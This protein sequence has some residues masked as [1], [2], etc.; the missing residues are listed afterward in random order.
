MER[1]SG[2]DYEY[3]PF[4]EGGRFWTDH[5]GTTFTGAV[6]WRERLLLYVL[7]PSLTA[8]MR[9]HGSKGALSRSK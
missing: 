5:N 7:T 8:Y 2:Y 6:Y 4:F 1:Q 9:P 3:F